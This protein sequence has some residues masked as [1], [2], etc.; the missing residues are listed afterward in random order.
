MLTEVWGVLCPGCEGSLK[1]RGVQF[2]LDLS[3]SVFSLVMAW[4]SCHPTVSREAF[5]FVLI[6]MGAEC[7]SV[8]CA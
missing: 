3:C 2:I 1:V 6:S 4:S 5:I 7:D 8:T